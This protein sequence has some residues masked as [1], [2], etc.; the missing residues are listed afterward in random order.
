[1]FD[2]LRDKI[3]TAKLTKTEKRIADYYMSNLAD[4]IFMTS[5]ELANAVV[6]SESSVIRFTHS[7]G[8]EGFNDF[9][10][11]IQGKYNELYKKNSS[12]LNSPLELLEQNIPALSDNLVLEKYIGKVLS[13][14]EG[15]I[16]NNTKSNYENAAKIIKKARKKFITGFISCSS[17][18]H[19]MS[20]ILSHMLP[21][22]INNTDI[23][24]T[25]EKL[26]DANKNDVLVL[27]SIPRYN[28][29]GL[30]TLK[31]AKNKDVKIIM[32]TDKMTAPGVEYADV[33]FLAPTVNVS[34]FN[35]IVA[36]M[37]IS[38][39][40]LNTLSKMLGTGNKNRLEVLEEFITSNG[41]Y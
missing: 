37:V 12:I 24:L 13:N 40:L 8:F 15:T 11:D 35:S 17:M 27:F 2:Y 34:F 32:I 36:P 29:M 16:E 23:G 28:K 7:L 10:K 1:M 30:E 14:I 18:A 22:V 39:V 31:F 9:K 4:A 33:L 38:E 3:V 5:T 26:L 41:L 6:V 21:D 25:F 20:Y 19:W